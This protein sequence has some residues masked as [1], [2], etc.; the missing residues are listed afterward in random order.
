M[1][2]NGLYLKTDILLKYPV[3]TQKLTGRRTIYK[4]PVL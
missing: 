2:L 4:N 3:K 1:K